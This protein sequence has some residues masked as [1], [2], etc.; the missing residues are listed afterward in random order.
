VPV[1][2]ARVHAY[3]T[4][5][6]AHSCS[7]PPVL[8]HAGAAV[9]LFPQ[10]LGDQWTTAFFREQ[11][12]EGG[13]SQRTHE[14]FISVT[15]CFLICVRVIF[16]RVSWHAHLC[17]V[18]HLVFVSVIQALLWCAQCTR[19]MTTRRDSSL[20]LTKLTLARL[21][22]LFYTCAGLSI[23][24]QFFAALIATTSAFYK[25]DSLAGKLLLPTNAWVVIATALNLSIYLRNK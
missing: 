21:P 19:A 16:A 8:T 15:A 22:T 14:L 2:V 13:E 17:H 1:A 25:V 24:V 23:I 9:L 20:H 10:A 4:M 12:I 7:I 18:C 5:H 11:Y 3:A 6:R